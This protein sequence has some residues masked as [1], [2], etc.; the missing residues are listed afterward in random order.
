MPVAG[1]LGVHQE[2]TRKAAS[3]GS[4]PEHA[5]AQDGIQHVPEKGL[6]VL[7]CEIRDRT[8]C[9][10]RPSDPLLV[11]RPHPSLLF[12]KI[13]LRADTCSDALSQL[14]GGCQAGLPPGRAPPSLAPDP[15]WEARPRG[16]RGDSPGPGVRGALADPSS[17]EGE[18]PPCGKARAGRPRVL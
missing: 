11:C 9:P 12:W 3:T 15:R 5:L 4:A 16:P 6:C 14:S 7:S 13:S 18:R 1:V 10:T 17:Q 8:S 2:K